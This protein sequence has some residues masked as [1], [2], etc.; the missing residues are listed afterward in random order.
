MKN[1]VKLV[2]G[3][4]ILLALISLDAMC[5]GSKPLQE[6]MKPKDA[7]KYENVLRYD[8]KKSSKWSFFGTSSCQY[9]FGEEIKVDVKVPPVKGQLV[10]RSQR[11]E[12]VLDFDG[13]SSWVS[14]N[15]RFDDRRDGIPLVIGVAG[16]G[17][18]VQYA[19]MYPYVF[20]SVRPEMNGR[21]KFF[22]YAEKGYV[23]SIGQGECQQPAGSSV[24]G[25]VLL[26]VEKAGEY[27]IQTRGCVLGGLSNVQGVFQAG[28]AK[29]EWSAS[30]D[31]T[32]FCL[33][34]SN[35]KYS[36]GSIEEHE[37]YLDWWNRSYVPLSAPTIN[38]DDEVEA[39]GPD[40]WKW[41]EI[42]GERWSSCFLRGKCRSADLLP[43][44]WG[45]ALA[46]DEHG[47]VS[48]MKAKK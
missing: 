29:I 26:N 20:D 48:F 19:K 24:D 16:Y 14:F 40:G 33:V 2:A 27:L 47:R 30:K 34:R 21:V 23:E 5:M 42:N 37:L 31:D 3:L 1:I 12:V 39:C 28:T 32:G 25:S 17:S 18:G 22:C 10:A 8:C 36:D 38:V 4:E 9:E 45:Y 35:V 46:W 43:G 44:N 6:T 15:W 41:L 7:N 11:K 13:E